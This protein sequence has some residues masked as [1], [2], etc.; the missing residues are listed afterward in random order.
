MVGENIKI[1]LKMAII[2]NDGAEVPG[3]L[4]KNPKNSM[5]YNTN[6]NQNSFAQFYNA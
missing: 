2:N 1:S 5:F 3:N 6:L 4:E